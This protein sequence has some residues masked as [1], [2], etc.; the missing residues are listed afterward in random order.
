MWWQRKIKLTQLAKYIIL[1]HIETYLL[2]VIQVIVITNNNCL[3]I[4]KDEMLQ[5]FW[6]LQGKIPLTL[7]G[8]RDSTLHLKWMYGP[9]TGCLNHDVYSVF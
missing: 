4:T 2:K 5:L 8:A 7:A 9:G 6:K 3:Y 1:N